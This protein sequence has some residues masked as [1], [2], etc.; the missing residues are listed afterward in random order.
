LFLDA[1]VVLRPDAVAAALF[2]AGRPGVAALSLLPRQCLG[3]VAERLIVP[4]AFQQYFMGFRH[5]GNTANGQFVLVRTAVYRASGG[6]AAVRGSIV[7]D[8]DLAATLAGFGDVLLLRGERFAGVRMYWD[9]AGIAEG[10][11]KNASVFLTRD[12]AGGTLTVLG[13]LT[14]AGPVLQLVTGLLRWRGADVLAGLAG[15]GIG[16]AGYVP[17]V[18]LFGKSGWTA[19]SHPLGATAFLVISLRSLAAALGLIPTR[20]KGRSY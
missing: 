7:E 1:D 17:W 12:P 13:S 6:H 15:T 18:R 19:A 16:I 9:F 2:R 20:W 3:S 5:R 10:F 14:A 11:G 4:L 8:V